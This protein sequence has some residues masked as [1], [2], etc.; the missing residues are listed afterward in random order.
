MGT[1]RWMI[2]A[3]GFMTVVSVMAFTTMLFGADPT[4]A[5]RGTL[6]VFYV[7]VF[8]ATAGI[9]AWAFMF[10]RARL[11]KTKR[12]LK[13]FFRDATRQGA[14]VGGILTISLLLQAGRHLNFLW[15]FFIVALAF[16]VEAYVTRQVPRT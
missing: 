2:I 8:I 3:Y 12:P 7:S 9:A 6:A 16:G 4:Y 11:S 10:V 14:L 1:S 15:V 13:L 5:D